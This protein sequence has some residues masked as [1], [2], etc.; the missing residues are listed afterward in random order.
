MH[1]CLDVNYLFDNLIIVSPSFLAPMNWMSWNG[2]VLLPRSSLSDLISG[3]SS[4]PVNISRI[5][6][7]KL[8]MSILGRLKIRVGG[9]RRCMLISSVQLVNKIHGDLVS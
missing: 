6:A 1:Y 3:A 2:E 9:F 7:P 5:N 8:Q 4:G